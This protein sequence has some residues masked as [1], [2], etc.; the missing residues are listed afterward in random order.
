MESITKLETAQGVQ[1]VET[2]L[3]VFE[4]LARQGGPCGLSDLAR[5]LGMHRAKAY[6][7][8][9]SLQRLGWVRQ[10]AASGLYDLGPAVRDLSL[11]WLARQNELN[12]AMS[13]ARRLCEA[14]G[15]TCFV[16]IWGAG[17]ATVARVFQ[18]SRVVAISI[19]EGAVLDAESSATGRV[20]S[21][22]QRD[23]PSFI[24]ASMRVRVR[25]D[26]F[27]AVEG[28][29]VRGINAISAPVFDAQ[30][31][32]VLALT[33]VGPSSSMD[34]SAA[35]PQARALLAA[36]IRLSMGRPDEATPPPASRPD[37]TAPDGP[38][39]R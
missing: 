28:D 39:E 9:V 29:H 21:V 18:P 36:C 1:S 20:F 38:R 6:R 23:H 8:L 27:A 26:G 19:A 34:T 31:R 22:W 24:P 32:L 15:E 25:A 5:R 33:L 17:G 3:M 16:A 11:Q 37:P 10:D 30:G 35:G 2:G 4:C 13:E 7:Y 14:Q 12:L